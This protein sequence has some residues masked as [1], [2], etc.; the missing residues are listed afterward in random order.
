MALRLALFSSTTADPSPAIDARVDDTVT[1]AELSELKT[2]M[3][4]GWI[5]AYAKTVSFSEREVVLR[6]V[7][8]TRCK[9]LR[10]KRI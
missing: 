1:P 6:T 3:E 5:F 7:A 2:A 10:Q 4:Q 9:Q 8:Q